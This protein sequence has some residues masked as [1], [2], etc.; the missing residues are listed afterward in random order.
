LTANVDLT[1]SKYNLSPANI[2]KAFSALAA[3]PHRCGDRQPRLLGQ[4]GNSGGDSGPVTVQLQPPNGAVTGGSVTTYD[5]DA[6]GVLAQ[7]V[8]GGG[9]AGGVIGAVGGNGGN[10]G[11]GGA[12]T[13]QIDSGSTVTTLGDF[14]DGVLAQSVGGGG[15]DAGYAKAYGPFFSA[16]IGGL[17][18]SGNSGGN[19][20]VSNSG[21]LITAGESAYGVIAQSIAGGGGNGGAANSYSVGVIFPAAM[22]LGGHGGNGGTGGAVAVSN[23]GTIITGGSSSGAPAAATPITLNNVTLNLPAGMDS[24][25][26]LAQSI[27]GGG[28]NGGSALAKTLA[29]NA[30]PELPTVSA[31]FA[32]GGSGGA[33]NSGGDVAVGNAGTVLTFGDGAHGV[34]A[35]S[36]GGGGGNGADSTAWAGAIQVADATVTLSTPPRLSAATP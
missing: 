30:V 12:V 27:G 28:G 35:Q 7:S 9:G 33:G 22:A 10:G 15:G 29:I 14:A 5:D 6:V 23:Q 31:S 11:A 24:I 36:I 25:G 18:G 17:G 21:A 8:G 20:S 19:V 32:L 2:E 34:L 1:R 13:V 16:A 4:S 26:I 3:Y